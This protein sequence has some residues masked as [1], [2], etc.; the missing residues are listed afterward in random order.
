[1]CESLKLTLIVLGGDKYVRI[2]TAIDGVSV[3]NVTVNH[4]CIKRSNDNLKTLTRKT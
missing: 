1:M 3:E 4:E 2:L